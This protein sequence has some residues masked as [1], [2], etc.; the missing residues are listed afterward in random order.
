ML[1]HGA[2]VLL[3]GPHLALVPGLAILVAVLVLNFVGD[4]LGD[5]LDPRSSTPQLAGEGT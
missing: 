2:E 1:D 4:G 5:W 3:L